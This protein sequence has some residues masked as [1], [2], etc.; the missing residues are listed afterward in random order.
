MDLPFT[1]STISLCILFVII[2]LV[3]SLSRNPIKT[4]RNIAIGSLACFMSGVLSFFTLWILLSAFHLH[5]P[6]VFIVIISY[7][8]AISA[9]FF[10]FFLTLSIACI[11]IKFLLFRLKNTFKD[12]LFVKN[13]SEN[14]HYAIFIIPFLAFLA[15]NNSLFFYYI[16]FMF[17]VQLVYLNFL[18]GIPDYFL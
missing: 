18:V 10:I 14:T 1:I 8:C 4:F 13:L 6:S 12:I 2:L 7:I 15:L 16:R 17:K 3:L 11:L 9:A 5:H